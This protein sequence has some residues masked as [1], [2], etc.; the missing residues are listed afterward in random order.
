MRSNA[1]TT[2]ATWGARAATSLSSVGGVPLARAAGCQTQ[3]PEMLAAHRQLDAQR[4]R[5]VRGPRGGQDGAV[6]P[7]DAHAARPDRFPHAGEDGVEQFARAGGSH[8]VAQLRDGCDGVGT[9]A[10]EDAVHQTLEPVAQRREPDR[11]GRRGDHSGQRRT[12]QPRAGDRREE[13]VH[14]NDARGQNRVHEAP[15]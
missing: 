7:V 1:R 6:R 15:A 9:P 11:D 13:G 8:P 4:V 3:N 5:P 2:T 12:G 14:G 10:V